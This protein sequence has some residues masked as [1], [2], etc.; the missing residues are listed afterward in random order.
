MPM[1]FREVSV[2]PASRPRAAH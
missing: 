1:D 2:S